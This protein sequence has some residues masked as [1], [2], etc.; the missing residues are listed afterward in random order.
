[1]TNWRR[2]IRLPAF[3]LW[4]VVAAYNTTQQV[5]PHS[6]HVLAFAIVLVLVLSGGGLYYLDNRR[7][8]PLKI[9]FAVLLAVVFRYF[10][11]SLSLG[12]IADAVF[13]FSVSFIATL[14]RPHW[15]AWDH[16]RRPWWPAFKRT[17]RRLRGDW[18]ADDA[19]FAKKV[20][21]R[22]GH[23]SESN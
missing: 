5:R 13:V 11:S 10:N 9:L 19:E 1:M 16:V 12:G 6:N 4:A 17:V 3:V 8:L 21:G 15:E 18:Q 23:E 2:W 14:L 20:L 22:N 7:F